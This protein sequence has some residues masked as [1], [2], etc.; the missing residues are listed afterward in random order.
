MARAD[1]RWDDRDPEP[2][3]SERGLQAARDKIRTPANLLIFAA[4]FMIFWS[5]FS[6]GL[7][8]SGQDFSVRMLETME[9]MQPAGKAKDDMHKQVEEARNRDR[10]GEYI[11]TAILSVVN[12]SLE[13]L[14]LIAA[15]RMKKFQS[16]TLCMAGAILAMVPYINSCCCI[17]LPIGI[18]ALVALSDGNV[19]A[20]FEMMKRGSANPARDSYDDRRYDDDPQA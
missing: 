6:L 3:I 11:Y 9:N 1:D 13:V 12:L 18:W 16:R 20:A 8:F 5:I 7:T 17:G 15:T 10:T 19:K 4:L 2:R 14:I